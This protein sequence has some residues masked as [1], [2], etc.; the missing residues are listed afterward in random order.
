M[1]TFIICVKHYKNCHSYDATWKLLENTLVSVCNQTDK[2]FDVIVVSN[3]TLDDFVGNTKIKNVKFIEVDWEPP[4]TS[5]NWQIRKQTTQQN[6]MDQIRIDRG[7][8][9]ILAL[10]Q[11]QKVNNKNHYV[12]FVDADDF[13][14]KDL[15]K[16]VNNSSKDF[17]RIKKGFMLGKNKTFKHMK[18]F[19]CV[20]GTSNI[21][22]I[23]LLKDGINFGEINKDS[24]QAKVIKTADNHYLKIIIGSHKWSFNHFENK[25]YKGEDIP[26]RAAIYN[27]THDEQ[28]S[29]KKTPKLKYE[30]SS[31]MIKDFS[32]KA[33]KKD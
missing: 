24:P 29:G 25:G 17:L 20:C 2:N 16:Y 27:C 14:H 5:D 8:K 28:H 18:N 33:L 4:A 15:A 30:C 31:K 26:F 1:I 32:I 23:E 6:G 9:Y 12:M 21:T 19:S 7:T 3:K 22:K 10:S 11:V 13:I